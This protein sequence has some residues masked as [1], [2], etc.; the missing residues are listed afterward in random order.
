MCNKYYHIL[1]SNVEPAV[2]KLDFR[3]TKLDF[4]LTKLDFRLT[5]L[6]FNLTKLNFYNRNIFAEKIVENNPL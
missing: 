6:D 3:L 2:T 5:K 1:Q 4:R